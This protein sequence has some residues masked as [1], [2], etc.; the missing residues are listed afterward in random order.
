MKNHKKIFLI[1]LF[2]L[3]LLISCYDYNDPYSQ[4]ERSLNNF[5]SDLVSHFPKKRTKYA[6]QSASLTTIADTSSKR[7]FGVW[8]R[9]RYRISDRI[10]I[11]SLINMYSSSAVKECYHNDSCNLLLPR[12]ALF[13]NTIGELEVLPCSN[14]ED[15]I[16][17]P[18]FEAELQDLNLEDLK[19]LPKSYTLYVLDA[20]SGKYVHENLL[21]EE[22]HMP[23]KWKHGYSKGVAVNKEKREAIYWIEIW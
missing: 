2:A 13:D 19:Y 7:R 11:D 6:F 14:S 17:V 3:F 18:L 22:G 21:M 16:P 5:D 1:V 4:I 10:D 15:I 8:A 12:K 20:K 9:V 23:E